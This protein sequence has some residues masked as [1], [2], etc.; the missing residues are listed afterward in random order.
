MDMDRRSMVEREV[1]FTSDRVA[2]QQRYIE[3]VKIP[4]FFNKYQ[5]EVFSEGLLYLLQQH[6][7]D[8][9]KR[10]GRNDYTLDACW[11]DVY[12]QGINII[13]NGDV[14]CTLTS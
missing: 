4:E 8:Y 6:L 11:T 3:K 12:Q 10:Q 1:A 2:L 7:C 9:R 5:G 13:Y 14:I